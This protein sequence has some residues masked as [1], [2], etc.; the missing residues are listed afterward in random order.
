[1]SE[2]YAELL[3]EV[4]DKT[5]LELG[6]TI[7]GE[8]AEGSAA[9]VAQELGGL[10]AFT[11]LDAGLIGLLRDQT[12]SIRLMDRRLGGEALFRQ[13]AAHVET[14]E[15]LVRHAL[16]GAQR[17]AAAD[18]LGQAAA[19]AGWQ[20]LDNGQIGEAWRLHEVATAAAR[21]SGELAGLSYARAQQAF[22][23]LD[24]GEVD[25]AQSLVAATRTDAGSGV[26]ATLQAW[27]LAAEG[28]ALANG[29]D[30]D[31]ALRVLDQAAD[32]M[33]DQPESELPYVM[34]DAGHLARW[35][36]HCLARLGE[37]S[38]IEELTGALVAMGE[39]QYGRAEVGLRVDLALAFH[40][41]GDVTEARLH[42]RRA[43]ELAGRTGSQRQRRRI[44]DLLAS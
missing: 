24:A 44:T 26:P 38:A 2:F 25:A 27:L 35:R 32:V 29:G 31:S 13:T 37:T 36:G 41:R 23:L 28:E 17:E 4:Y 19:L 33:P 6:L 7:A 5:V 12:Q 42:A 16:P 39:G 18:E 40:A 43:N 9:A 20:A 22:V 3:C 30:R 14:I 21:E 34:L 8:A 1:M 10:P 11:R 15:S